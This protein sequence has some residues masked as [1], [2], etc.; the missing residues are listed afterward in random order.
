MPLEF[1]WQALAI[2]SAVGGLWL[3]WNYDGG[4]RVARSIGLVSPAPERLQKVCRETATRMGVP[5][6]EVLLLGGF[7]AQ[8]F[9]VPSTRQLLFSERI[10]EIL[11]DAELAAVCSH[12]LAHLTES[13]IDQCKRFI[14]GFMFSPWLL[15]KPVVH[16]FGMLGFIFLCL[17]TLLI[18]FIFQK[19]SHKLEVRADEIATKSQLNEGSYARALERLHE[20]NLLP[21]VMAKD[22]LTHPH[23]YDRL[24]AAGISPNFPRP[25]PAKSTAWNGILISWATGILA[26]ILVIRWLER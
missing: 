16:H 19:F 9:A 15:F 25:A 2:T 23:L 26:C 8:A 3:F 6:K 11:S 22:Q 7:Q 13:K 20:D 24:I 5:V 10:L 14:L 4:I 18:P 1:N 12:E 17:N 21:A